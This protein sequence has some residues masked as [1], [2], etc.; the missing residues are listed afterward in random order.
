M[1]WQKTAPRAGL[2]IQTQDLC[3]IYNSKNRGTNYGKNDVS[4]ACAGHCG[5]GICLRPCRQ[6]REDGR[7][8]RPHER[9]CGFHQRRRKRVPESGI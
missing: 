9:N 1:E 2:L 5:A 8:N 3:M 7:G 6:G 4:G